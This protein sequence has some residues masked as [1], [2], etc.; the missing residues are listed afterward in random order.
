MF[1]SDI[2][3]SIFG[4]IEKG[5]TKTL[6]KSHS[7]DGCFYIITEDINEGRWKVDHLNKELAIEFLNTIKSIN[8][9]S[10]S[11]YRFYAKQIL[12]SEIGQS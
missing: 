12:K 8:K 9:I 6:V 5:I 1:K 2:C 4:E 7:F 10:D 3:I 11:D